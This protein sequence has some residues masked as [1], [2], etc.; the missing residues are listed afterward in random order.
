M[1]RRQAL[2]AL[3]CL[4]LAM[5]ATM[6]SAA[7]AP[8]PLLDFATGKTLVL[9]GK[10]QVTRVLFRADFAAFQRAVQ[11]AEDSL[12]KFEDARRIHVDMAE[13]RRR[14]GIA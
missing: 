5:K 6:A 11:K 14:L 7:M 13:V 8:E 3:C 1:N 4:P 9:H 12:R 10:E 2:T